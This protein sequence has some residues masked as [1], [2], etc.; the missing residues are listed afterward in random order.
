MEAREGFQP[1]GDSEGGDDEVDDEDEAES[2]RINENII[3]MM[4]LKS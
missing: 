4:T 2:V 3:A 1:E